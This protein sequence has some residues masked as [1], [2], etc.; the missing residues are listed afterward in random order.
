MEQRFRGE[1]I[2]FLVQSFRLNQFP[3]ELRRFWPRT[4]SLPRSVFVAGRRLEGGPAPP[5]ASS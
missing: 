3:L 1:P 5:A 2:K 4:T